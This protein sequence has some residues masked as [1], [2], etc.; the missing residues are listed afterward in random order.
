L[1]SE[2]NL[3]EA[4]RLYT[5]QENVTIGETYYGDFVGGKNIK[6][7]IGSYSEHIFELMDPS[8]IYETVQW[9]EQAFNGEAASGIFVTAPI[10][11]IFS[12][13]S[14]FGLI[15]LTL[16]L[17]VYLSNYIFNGKIVNPEKELL[18]EE[19]EPSKN[20]LIKYYAFYVMIIGFFISIILSDNLTD[21]VPLYSAN[22]IFSLIIG[23]TIGTII[24]YNLLILNKQEKLNIKSFPLKIKKL[25]LTNSG[26]SLLFGILAALLLI[27]ALSVT[28]H[29][30]PQNILPN[31]SEIV[32]MIGI[33]LISFPFFLIKEVYFR[34]VQGRLKSSNTIREYFSMVANGIFMDNLFIGII[35][36]VGWI[37][38]IEMP[39]NMH[40]LLVWIIFSIIQQFLVTWVYMWSGRNI[41]GST[42][43]LC[44][45]YAWISVIFLPS[46]GFL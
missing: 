43:F 1:V 23:T 13:I 10:F 12:Y 2:E 38:L 39:G 17:I 21:V 3:L 36:L 44:I 26:R 46:L 15:T 41:L 30:N 9:F 22:L 34:T 6:S 32:I 25:C 37:H 28:W 4:L 45:F 27:S 5:E 20:N 24:I 8:I 29:W 7:F 11:Q 14:L 31:T 19:R 42:I 33:T 35:K 18:K 16:T 40:Y